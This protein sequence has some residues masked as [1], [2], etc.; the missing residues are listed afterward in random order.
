MISRVTPK[1][2]TASRAAGAQS[3]E[4]VV[5]VRATIA[6]DGHVSYVDPLSGPMVLIPSVMSAVR[7][8]SYEPS[9]LDGEPFPTEVELTIRF[10]ALR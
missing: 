9:M 5:S 2:P 1:P 3:G 8:W 7:E 6:G 10:R 4:Q